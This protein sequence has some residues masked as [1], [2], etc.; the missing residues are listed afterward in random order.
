MSGNRMNSTMT[1]SWFVEIIVEKH[2]VKHRK[3]CRQQ[4][5]FRHSFLYKL[6]SNGLKRFLPF[7]EAEVR[8]DKTKCGLTTTDISQALPQNAG[9]GRYI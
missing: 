1:N 4:I 7:L 9:V 5:C 8:R 6:Y 2:S 3:E